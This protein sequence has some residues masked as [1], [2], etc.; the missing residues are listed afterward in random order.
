MMN[1]EQ[2]LQFAKSSAVTAYD[3]NAEY[4]DSFLSHYVNLI[5]T[6]NEEK[7]SQFIDEAR[8][9]YVRAYMELIK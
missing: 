1:R 3:Q 2:A 5:D 8:M 4:K 9:E 7:A 6:L